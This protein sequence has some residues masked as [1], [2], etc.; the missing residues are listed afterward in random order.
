MAPKPKKKIRIPRG[1]DC[2]PWLEAAMNAEIDGHPDKRDRT[3]RVAVSIYRSAA[4]SAAR[5]E[6]TDR[7]GG[8]TGKREPKER[9]ADMLDY[10]LSLP[11]G[12][13][14]RGHKSRWRQAAE[15]YNKD[16][17]PEALQNIARRMKRLN[18]T[19]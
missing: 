19:E 18:P 13:G 16:A 5:R 3:F 11:E 8:T 1:E 7:R 4:N 12:G 10:A 15:H 14:G 9:D 6:R 2:W 17:S